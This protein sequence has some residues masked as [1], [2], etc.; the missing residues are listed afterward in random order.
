VLPAPPSPT[1]AEDKLNTPGPF[2]ADIPASRRAIKVASPVLAAH[3]GRSIEEM[4]ILVPQSL[5]SD[6]TA[7]IRS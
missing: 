4:A 5:V 3:I 2:Q 1:S 6:S 7:P